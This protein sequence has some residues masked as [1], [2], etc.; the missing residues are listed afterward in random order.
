[1]TGVRQG[2][3]NKCPP[4]RCGNKRDSEV[5]LKNDKGKQS[6]LPFFAEWHS[7]KTISLPRSG[8]RAWKVPAELTEKERSASVYMKSP[9][10]AWV[11]GNLLGRGKEKPVCGNEDTRRRSKGR[12][13]EKSKEAACLWGISRAQRRE[14]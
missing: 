13:G 3:K 5:P 7:R 11:R 14:A 1:M 8:V 9:V 6:C 12:R 10:F 2:R 4:S